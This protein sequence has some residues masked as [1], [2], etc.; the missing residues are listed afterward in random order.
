M[1]WLRLKDNQCGIPRC[2][3]N[4]TIHVTL[5]FRFSGEDCRLNAC[6]EGRNSGIITNGPLTERRAG[7]K[8][9]RTIL[10]GEHS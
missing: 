6:Q 2:A 3:R 8:E 1:F 7:K 5:D 10:E 4:D 9:A